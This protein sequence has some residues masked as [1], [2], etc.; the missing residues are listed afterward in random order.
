MLANTNVGGE[1][2]HRG[3][4]LGASMGAALGESGIPPRFIQGLAATREIKEE[5]DAFVAA[6]GGGKPLA[7][8]AQ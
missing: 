8:A 7:A 3:S 4:A 5:I 6:I 1:N 2:C